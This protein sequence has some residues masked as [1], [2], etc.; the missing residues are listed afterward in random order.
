MARTVDVRMIDAL[1]EVQRLDLILDELAAQESRLPH[2]AQVAQIAQK[3]AEGHVLVKKL[4][5]G[6]TGIDEKIAQIHV[7][8]KQLQE[9]INREQTKIDA[10]T[11][12]YRQI[13][14]LSTD[15]AAHNQR[16]E[17]AETEELTLMESRE[18]TKQ[19]IATYNA[20]IAK[21]DGAKEKTL[22]AYRQQMAILAAKTVQTTAAR[23]KKRAVIDEDILA[24]YDRLRAQKG[25][26][27]IGQFDGTRCSACSLALP[28]ALAGDFAHAG[29]V[30]ICSECKRI[31]VY[32]SDHEKRWDE[33]E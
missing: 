22:L 27:V 3:I 18:A 2:K 13:K 21:L 9:K 32:L 31:L 6:I 33:D 24:D 29:D 15:I 23:D 8:I 19:R 10:G 28:T 1:L 5:A 16:I 7:D 25:G 14:A 26:N 17:D 20:N 12:D 11:V 30:G 4:E